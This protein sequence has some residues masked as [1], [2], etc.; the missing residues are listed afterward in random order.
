ML[1]IP[2][3]WVR[4]TWRRF[5]TTNWMKDHGFLEKKRMFA[6]TA[7]DIIQSRNG[8]D[9]LCTVAN[10]AKVSEAILLMNKEGI[11]QIPV[12]EG[13]HF[14]GQRKLFDLLEK[15]HGRS[16]W[17]IRRSRKWW[18]NR[19]SLLRRQY[20]RCAFVIPEQG[21]QSRAGSWW[22][23]KCTSLPATMYWRRFLRSHNLKVNKNPWRCRQVFF[24]HVRDY[25]LIFF[26]SSTFRRLS[27]LRFPKPWKYRFEHAFLNQ[28]KLNFAHFIP[29]GLW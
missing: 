9:S 25:S 17:K 23:S 7:R 19:C 6:S 27:R 16:G 26:S 20:T 2:L 8:K 1:M 5:I 24:Y 10:K 29:L 4:V 13:E 28:V 3:P 11:D 18:T 22:K 14:I 15:D 12:T 21:K